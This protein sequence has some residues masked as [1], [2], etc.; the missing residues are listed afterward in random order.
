MTPPEAKKP[1]L[2]IKA[3]G[4][5]TQ[6]NGGSAHQAQAPPRRVPS[7]D[8]AGDAIYIANGHGVANQSEYAKNRPKRQVRL[9]ACC[10]AGPDACYTVPLTADL[11]SV[12]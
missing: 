5:A 3:E 1:R 12:L 10:Q 6:S 7:P 11:S 8:S 2:T 9:G 4:A